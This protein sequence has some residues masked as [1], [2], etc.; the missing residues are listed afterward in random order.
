MAPVRPRAPAAGARGGQREGLS[1]RPGARRS[2]GAPCGLRGKAAPGPPC[3]CCCL[4]GA[5][6]PPGGGPDPGTPRGAAGVPAA[7]S[8]PDRRLHPET[9]GA[10]PAASD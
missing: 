1:P 5:P 2:T 3:S 9:P 4:R 6:G 8:A 7:A 10:A